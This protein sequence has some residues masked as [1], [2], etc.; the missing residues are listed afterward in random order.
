MLN[1][2]GYL[3]FDMYDDNIKY[4]IILKID[5]TIYNYKI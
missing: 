4:K 3:I 2:N 5:L 1:D